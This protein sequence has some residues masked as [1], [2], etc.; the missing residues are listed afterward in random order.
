IDLTAPATVTVHVGATA[1]ELIVD[2]SNG[3]SHTFPDVTAITSLTIN[4]SSGDDS[5][6][7]QSV[8]TNFTALTID[9]GGGS[10]SLQ[11]PDRDVVWQLTGIGVGLVYLEA[12]SQTPVK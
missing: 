12:P 6:T 11:G 5:F 4:G 2:I 8:P 7:V 3:E 9:G 10:D 1:T